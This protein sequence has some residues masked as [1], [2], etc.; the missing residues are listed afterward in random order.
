MSQNERVLWSGTPS[1]INNLG[2]YIM[3]GL[4]SPLVIPLLYAVWRW[5]DTRATRVELTSQRI[6]QRTG[7]LSRRTDETELYRVKD[8]AVVQPFLLRLFGLANLE[9][10][11]SDRTHPVMRIAALR[12]AEAVRN[13]LRHAVEARRQTTG[14]REVDA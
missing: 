7:V 1:Q 14:V 11:T 4:L 3:C 9:I 13:L 6:I 8:F 10:N 5:L 12:E 2:T